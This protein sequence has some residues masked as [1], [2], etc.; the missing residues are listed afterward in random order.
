MTQDRENLVEQMT[1]AVGGVDDTIRHGD[2]RTCPGCRARATV[3]LD[4]LLAR[5]RDPRDQL[6]QGLHRATCESETT[7]RC[8]LRD[9][10]GHLAP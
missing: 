2:L 6:V 9:L 10:A 3:A 5:L 4:A 1:M 7:V 8:F